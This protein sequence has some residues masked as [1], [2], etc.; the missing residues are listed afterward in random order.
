MDCF[1][2]LFTDNV[3]VQSATQWTASVHTLH[4][5]KPVITFVFKVTPEILHLL[6]NWN[7]PNDTKKGVSNSF[8]DQKKPR[9]I[10]K[11]GTK[12]T[13]WRNM[14][15]HLCP[16]DQVDSQGK[17]KRGDLNRLSVHQCFCSAIRD[18]QQPTFPVYAFPIFKTSA[19][20]LCGTTGI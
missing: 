10:V 7:Y 9:N 8:A 2:T 11:R 4:M 15:G 17:R 18:S 12:C 20:A 16:R 6:S 19:T 1:G 5:S 3:H 13:K 14:C